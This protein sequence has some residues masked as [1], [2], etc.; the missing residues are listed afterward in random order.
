ML[1]NLRY[2]ELFSINAQ[3]QFF[4]REPLKQYVLLSDGNTQFRSRTAFLMYLDLFRL[5][6]FR[7]ILDKKILHISAFPSDT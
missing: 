3:F 2:I 7:K 1:I 4:R 6:Y 5:P